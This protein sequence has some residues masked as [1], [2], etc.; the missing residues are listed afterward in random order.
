VPVRVPGDQTPLRFRRTGDDVADF[1]RFCKT[2]LRLAGNKPMLLRP[3]QVEIV[4]MVW[5]E[6]R[7]KLSALAIG[8]G[9]AKSTLA[10]AMCLY[11][12]YVGEGESIDILAV[13]ERQAGLI[14]AICTK[15]AGR[16][17][18][19]AKRATVFRDRLEVRESELC[20]L[21]ANAAALE[22]RT[23]T[24]VCCDEG[25]RI[26][27]E[28]YEVAVMSVSK[29]PD[30]QLFLIGTPGPNPRNVLAQ[31][32]DHA[33][34]H[35]EDTSQAYMEFS[36]DAWPDHALDCD[37]HDG[38]SGC[39]S[40]ANPALGDWLTSKSLLATAP[41]KTSESHWRRV[42]LIQWR[43]TNAEPPLPLGLWEGLATGEDIPDRERVVLAFDGSYSGNDATVIVAA[44]VSPQPH[45][46]LVRWWGRPDPKDTDYRIPIPE[47]EQALRDAC[48]RWNVV[49]I[50]CDS[51]RWQ[52][53]LSI[54][55]G[56]GLPVKDFPQ[57]IARMSAATAGF[58]DAC[59]NAQLGHSGHP[60]IGEHLNNAV[61]TEDNRGGRL[62]KAHRS[63]RIDAAITTVMAVS[64]ATWHG[65]KS[66]PK[67]KR[68]LAFR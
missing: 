30:A 44:T 29:L 53:S 19:L 36:A 65:T 13:D 40:A 68:T 26:D 9:N 61:L 16:H 31:F 17:E 10:A 43:V 21:P 59:R 57:S 54:L 2:Y 35:P 55:E 4:R 1:E 37:D 24:W 33:I 23:P 7:P 42:R 62:V 64:R 45:V 20:W 66:K 12:L 63:L 39:L 52:R 22:G 5:G 14:G 41:P 47:V 58:L 15:M 46:Q 60:L 56:E 6:E 8:R 50:A 3:W 34:A 51:Y 25:G 67:P 48:A 49:E 18:Q 27:Q 32:R 11:R 38:G 28:V